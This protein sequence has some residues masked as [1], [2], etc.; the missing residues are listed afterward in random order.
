MRKMWLIIFAVVIFIAGS[1]FGSSLYQQYLA[2]YIP[3]ATPT[4]PTFKNCPYHYIN[5][6]RCEP[7]QAPK[8]KEYTT[9]RN[10]LLDYINQQKQNGSLTTASV[11]FRD[12]ENGPVLS[13]NGDEDFAPASLLKVPLLIT[14]LR[15]AQDDP[16]VLER[17]VKVEGNFASLPEQ[18]IKPEQSATIGETYSVNELLSLLIVESDNNSWEALLTDLRK[19]YSENDFI[20]TL[21][22]LG[23]ID[24]RKSTDAQYVTVE[25]YASI[26]RLLYNSSYLNAPMS[27]KALT[28]LTQSDFQNGI[29]AGVP[30]G[31]KV[32]HKFGERKAGDD[33]QL[34]DC[35]I[36]YYT[37]DPY[38]ICI[39]TRGHDISVLEP[40]IQQISQ[41]V[42]KEVQSRNQ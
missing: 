20:A 32:A 31:T 42:F 40:I 3:A 25:S 17:K 18:N 38:L 6:L 36:V 13:I 39:M 28:L 5:Q 2:P 19:T 35:G 30:T 14:Y 21:S 16:S 29:I 12:L 33:Q 4:N 26:F 37:P 34:H 27:D 8:K 41:N 15:K 24:P 23:I 11:Y 22:D 9:L 1:I 10:D 7:D